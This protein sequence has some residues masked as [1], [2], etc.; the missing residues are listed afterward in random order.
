MLN[1]PF[2]FDLMFVCFLG[3]VGHDPMKEHFVQFLLAFLGC[4]CQ[5]LLTSKSNKHGLF[6]SFFGG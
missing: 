4:L 1:E 3:G 5:D 6:I 2:C